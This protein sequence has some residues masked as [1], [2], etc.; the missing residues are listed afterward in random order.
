MSSWNPWHGC[1][2]ISA[3]CLNC[4]VYRTDSKHDKD[5]SV[6]TKTANFNLPVQKNRKGEYKLQPDAEGIV[7]TCFTSDFFHED[8]DEWRKEVWQMIKLRNDLHF[9]FITKRIH[10]STTAFPTTGETATT[11][12]PSAVLRKIRI[13][14]ITGCHSF[15]Q[16]R[17]S[18][19]SS[20]VSP[21]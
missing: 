2:K 14:R 18:I 7:Y 6:I 21:C 15:Y 8:T 12:S 16:R 17:S 11:M 19:R 5:S 13:G 10:L 3:G 20:S 4:Y 1:T 9:L